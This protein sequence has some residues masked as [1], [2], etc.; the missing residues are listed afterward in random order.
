MKKLEHHELREKIPQIPRLTPNL[1]GIAQGYNNSYLEPSA[2]GNLDGTATCA[3]WAGKV[4]GT[5]LSIGPKNVVNLTTKVAGS[6][7]IYQAPAIAVSALEKKILSATTNKASTV[8]AQSLVTKSTSQVAKGG[9]E[10]TKKAVR[11][12]FVADVNAS[13][14]H[15]V[16]R[17]DPLSGKITHY[18]M[19][20]PQTNLRNPNAWESVK[21][22]D[23]SGKFK[24]SHFNKVLDKH[25]FE[26]HIHD[27]TFPGGVR[28]A[29]LWE[30]P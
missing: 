22:F 24:Q 26:P 13:G 28:P 17:K 19:F 27:P 15:T 3:N 23:N 5:A 18:E 11:N 1:E 16:F 10:V 8:A 7:A 6:L 30:I 29:H 14:A 4:I 25:I 9:A 21:R 2:L 20:R 12:T